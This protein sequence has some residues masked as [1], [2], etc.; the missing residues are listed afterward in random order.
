M[1]FRNYSCVFLAVFVALCVGG[2]ARAQEGGK[3]ALHI[4]CEGASEGAAVSFDGVFKGE[5]PFDIIVPE[6]TI[7]L[8][9]VKAVGELRES[10]FEQT[11]RIGGGT[12]KPIEIILSEPRL[13]ARGLALKAQADKE[14][15]EARLR[16]AEVARAAAEAKAAAEKAAEAAAVANADM[17]ADKMIQARRARMGTAG[18]PCPDCLG[19]LS[20]AAMSIDMPEGGDPLT[21]GWIAEIQQDI[22]RYARQD[23]AF[24]LPAEQLPAPCESALASFRKVAKLVDFSE[25]SA[26]DKA[27]VIS[28]YGD[29]SPRR[30]FRDVRLWPIS[31][32]CVDG[33][34]DGVAE[35]WI[36][37]NAVLGTRSPGVIMTYPMFIKVKA[38]FSAGVFTRDLSLF[39]RRGAALSTDGNARPG[40]SDRVI[41]TR[42][43]N[44]GD[45]EAYSEISA[46]LDRPTD[47]LIILSAVPILTQYSTQG[48]DGK[49]VRMFWYGKVYAGRTDLKNDLAHGWGTNTGNSFKDLPGNTRRMSSEKICYQNNKQIEPTP[50]ECPAD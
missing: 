14:A 49:G 48:A 15:A 3:G 31:G 24:R 32:T 42:R 43:N 18:S 26:A 25:L 12:R 40:G 23:A 5:C 7:A 46:V 16:A 41:F 6:G 27:N 29:V 28:T 4:T 30:Y 45:K 1:N 36:S 2:T 10:V 9:A 44:G 22:L 39:S 8:R 47:T 20:K 13:N 17:I 34:L 35:A 19:L 11:Y 21:V 37:A 50:T 33:K 38:S